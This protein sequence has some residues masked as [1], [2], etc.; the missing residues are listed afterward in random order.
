MEIAADAVAVEVTYNLLDISGSHANG[1]IGGAIVEP[2][3]TA[4]VFQYPTTRERH[5]RHLSA[6]LVLGLRPEHPL[7]AAHHYEAGVVAVEQG[8]TQAIDRTGDR[9]T[10]AV[11]ENE[12]SVFG[13][14]GWRAEANI[15]RIPPAPLTCVNEGRMVTPVTQVGAP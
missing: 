1:G 7:V 5:V 13:E 15:V 12:P 6:K 10:H 2:D 4:I 11:I 9:G 8:E 14:Q 3:G